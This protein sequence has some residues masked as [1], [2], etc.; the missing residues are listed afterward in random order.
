MKHSPRARR[1]SPVLIP[2]DLSL[3]TTMLSAPIAGTPRA[4]PIADA[5]AI[6]ALTAASSLLTEL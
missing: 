1:L 3:A 4:A 6:V 2:L 5:T